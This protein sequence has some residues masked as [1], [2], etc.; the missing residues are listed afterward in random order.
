MIPNLHQAFAHAQLQ[1]QGCDWDT[2]FGSR[3]FNLNGMT[4][5][6]ATLLANATAGEESRAWQEASA[7]LDR[8]EAVAALA[9]EH[10]QAALELA[11]AGDWDAALSRAQLACDLE[12][13]YHIHCVWAEF[14]NAIQAERDWAPAV[15]P[16]TVWQTGVT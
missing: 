7:W 14:R 4:A 13:P 1:W 2:A 16:A 12:A 10:G 3:L 15:P 8:L 11:L 6:Q 5:R 9:R